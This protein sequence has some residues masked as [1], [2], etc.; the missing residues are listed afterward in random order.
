[1]S[2]FCVL[3]PVALMGQCMQEPMGGAYNNYVYSVPSGTTV[4]ILVDLIVAVLPVSD[5]ALSTCIDEM[6]L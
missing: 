4:T 6:K 2:A 1:M 5:C 3:G